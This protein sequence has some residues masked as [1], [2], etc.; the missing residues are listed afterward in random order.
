VLLQLPPRSVSMLTIS[1]DEPSATP[2]TQLLGVTIHSGDILVSRGGAPT[3]SLI[4]RGNDFPGNFSH[5]AIVYVDETTG[6]PTIIESHIERGVTAS[7]IEEYLHDIKLRIMVLRLRHD[8]PALMANP[9]LPHAAAQWALATARGRH[10]PYDF[11]LD[12]RDSSKMFCSEVVSWAY[13]QEGVELWKGMSTISSPGVVSWLRGF[14]VEHFET[15]QPSDLEYDPQLRVVAEWRDPQTLF[16]DHVDNAVMETL[17]ERAER[18]EELKVSWYSL[19]I[20]RL[21]KAYSSFV[22]AF[23]AVGPIPEGMSASSA[24]RHQY[25]AEMH[26]AL[27]TRVLAKAEEF[28]RERGYAAPYWELLTFAREAKTATR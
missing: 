21:V 24:L 14:G 27:V 3:S 20:V 2:T 18:G 10:I 12:Y 15:M 26:M 5:I 7:P 1:T 6:V 9:R 19:P 4:A 13:L 11:A 28:R 8:H 23:G 25:F 16:K 17:L 22:N